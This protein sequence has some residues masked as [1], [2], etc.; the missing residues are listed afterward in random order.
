MHLACMRPW[1][2]SGSRQRERGE[3]GR[4]KRRK[5]EEGNR[6]GR[7]GGKK[8]ERGRGLQGRSKGTRASG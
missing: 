7:K 3:G 2:H 6:R 5:R 1:V 8:R 4:V